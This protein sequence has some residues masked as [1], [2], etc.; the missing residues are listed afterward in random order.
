MIQNNTITKLL[1]AGGLLTTVLTMGACGTT[2]SDSPASSATTSTASSGSSASEAPAIA[3]SPNLVPVN[4]SFSDEGIGAS[5]TI[6]QAGTG[7]I[8][9]LP[10]GGQSF[11]PKSTDVRMVGFEILIDESQKL[12]VNAGISAGDFTLVAADGKTTAKCYDPIEK[13]PETLAIVTAVSD[14]QSNEVTY[15]YDSTAKTQHGWI[16]CMTDKT[17]D[18]AFNSTGY[19]IHYERDDGTVRDDGSAVPGFKF[20]I[21]VKS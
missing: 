14:G 8:A 3:T 21:K 1:V 6:V 18:Q 11:G 12:F 10:R 15:T 4:E 19:T 16:F 7:W 9:A 17:N 2:G 13:Y 20:D 5:A